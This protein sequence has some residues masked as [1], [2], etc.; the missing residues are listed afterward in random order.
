MTVTPRDWSLIQSFAPGLEE[1]YQR[2]YFER[3]KQRQNAIGISG[4][5][6]FFLY[7]L[8]DVWAMQGN[9]SLISLFLRLGLVC[10]LILLVMWAARKDWPYTPFMRAYGTSYATAC[11][12]VSLIVFLGHFT[13]TYLP[14]Q[15]LLLLILFGY[16]MMMMPFLM[17]SI[18]SL[19]TSVLYLLIEGQVTRNPLDFGYQI[20]FFA[21]TNLMGL[22]GSYIQEY[23]LRTNFLRERQLEQSR[24]ALQEENGRKTHLMAS[25][26]HD[27]K[28][29]LLAVSLL[30]DELEASHP[31]PRPLRLFGRIRE[32]LSQSSSLNDAVM[33]AAQL[34]A[35]AIQPKTQILQLYPLVF[36]ITEEFRPLAQECSIKLT[37]DMPRG[38]L[39]RSDPLLLSRIFRNLIDNALKH[40]G[41]SEIQ[42]K[43]EVRG[44]QLVVEVTDNGCG[45]PENLR[46]PIFNPFFRQSSTTE[47]LG[48]GLSI[49]RQLSELLSTPLSLTN[50]PGGGSRFCLTLTLASPVM[51][52]PSKT[53][54]I[55]LSDDNSGDAGAELNQWLQK[56]QTKFRTCQAYGELTD[57]DDI[58]VVSGDRLAGS[59]PFSD[60]FSD[61]IRGV[62]LLGGTPDMVERLRQRSLSCVAI[63]LPLKPARVRLALEQLCEELGLELVSAAPL[64]RAQDG[65]IP[66]V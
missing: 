54:G 58:L 66:S 48:L 49:V 27:L 26:S 31:H 45:I 21:T 42:I 38:A 62:L 16:F 25:A 43:G 12:S 13:D 60:T 10:P 32:A 7:S 8:F 18:I 1:A 65:R 34:D 30:L 9:L 63:P 64:D 35:G 15:G 11:L 22:V 53:A 39:V 24:Q 23:N 52:E 46:Q 5:L 36:A 2:Y 57:A 50:A 33:A 3:L 37:L 56:W 40:S 41:A 29:P 6:L 51:Q 20:I 59:R 4:L 61:S 44:I 47:G 17:V 14:Y 19:L 55:V 28:Q